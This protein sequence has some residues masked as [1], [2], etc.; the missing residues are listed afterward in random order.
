MTKD[1]FMVNP[2][3]LGLSKGRFWSSPDQLPAVRIIARVLAD[4]VEKDL[5]ILKEHFGM[6]A[7]I[8]TWER[9]LARHEVAETVVPITEHMLKKLV[10]DS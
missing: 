4:P 7:I 2:H 9:L 10:N 5:E 3:E 1:Y 8:E 6:E